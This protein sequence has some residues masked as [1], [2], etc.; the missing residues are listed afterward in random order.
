MEGHG[1]GRGDGSDYNRS[2]D[3]GDNNRSVHETNGIYDDHNHTNTVHP[4][5]SKTKGSQRAACAS[6]GLAGRARDGAFG[7]S[8]SDSKQID[9]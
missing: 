3:N 9:W 5:T 8:M 2:R 7:A 4:P 1:T 6:A